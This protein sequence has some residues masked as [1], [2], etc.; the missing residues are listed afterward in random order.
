MVN[1]RRFIDK[2]VTLDEIIEASSYLFDWVVRHMMIPGRIESWL[3]IMDLKD[4]GM[5]QLPVKQLKGFV[6]S[7]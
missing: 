5:T 3:I 2:N 6:S 1:V 4:V 7:L